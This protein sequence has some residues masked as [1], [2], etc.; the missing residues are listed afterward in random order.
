MRALAR[1]SFKCCEHEPVQIRG[2]TISSSS[3]RMKMMTTTSTV[4]STVGMTTSGTSDKPGLSGGALAGI[5]AL[6]II[7]ILLTIIAILVVIIVVLWRTRKK[8]N[9]AGTA[10]VTI[11]VDDSTCSILA[12]YNGKLEVSV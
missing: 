11:N 6:V 1:T 4:S 10:S 9:Q 3:Y 5:T 12:G 7:I 2:N 8:Q